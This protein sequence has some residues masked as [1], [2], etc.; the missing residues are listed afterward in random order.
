MPDDQSSSSLA[1]YET[2]GRF[3]AVPDAEV[4]MDGNLF[5]PLLSALRVGGQP[6]TALGMPVLEPV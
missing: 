1:G 4:C 5:E 3:T 2:E 6:V